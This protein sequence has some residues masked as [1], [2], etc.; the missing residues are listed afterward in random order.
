MSILFSSLFKE[1]KKKAALP[2]YPILSHHDP[3]A[4]YVFV[5]DAS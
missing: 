4:M 5:E 3:I 1:A 2:S